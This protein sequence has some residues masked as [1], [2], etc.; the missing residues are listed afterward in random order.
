MTGTNAGVKNVMTQ[1]VN[2]HREVNIEPI[3]DITLKSVN[4]YSCFTNY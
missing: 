2:A 4:I 1:K 3:K